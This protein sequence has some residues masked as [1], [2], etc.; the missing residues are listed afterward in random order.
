MK[1][2]V[3]DV[4]WSKK[5]P[6]IFSVATPSKVQIYSMN[7][8]SLY[9]YVPKWYKVPVGTAI[10]PSNQLVSYNERDGNVLT[11]YQLTHKTE[12]LS[13]RLKDLS[14]LTKENNYK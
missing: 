10:G 12:G 3:V 2:P 1:E 14:K 7:E 9:S 13:N 4:K 8:N 5:L 11:E 6:S